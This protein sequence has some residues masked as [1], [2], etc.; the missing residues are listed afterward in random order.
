MALMLTTWM[1]GPEPKVTESA[2][3]VG[4]VDE[5]DSAPD[6]FINHIDDNV[7]SYESNHYFDN[8]KSVINSNNGNEAAFNVSFQEVENALRMAKLDN[9]GEL[10]LDE[11]ALA[12]LNL[13]VSRLP[14][15]LTPQNIQKIQSLIMKA[16]PG[17]A[18]EQVAEVL[19]NYYHFKQA[20]KEWLSSGVAV[21]SLQAAMD[22]LEKVSAMRQE[23]LGQDMADKLFLRQQQKASL[24]FQSMAIQQNK[25]LSA[26]Q[27]E[28][29]LAALSLN[30][31]NSRSN[32]A[33]LDRDDAGYINSIE[34][35]QEVQRLNSDIESMRI[36][37]ATHSDI[38]SKR[39]EVLGEQ[40]ASQ[41]QAMETQKSQWENRYQTYK[42]DKQHILESAITDVDKQQ[43]I[44]ALL[45]EHYSNDELAGARAY[46]SQQAH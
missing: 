45:S 15:N 5:F 35:N 34:N 28:T 3:N 33:N 32:L 39:V 11:Q 23:Y 38:H 2:F 13:V 7:I 30:N 43:Q 10:I 17:E 24:S 9:V 12:S 6:D 19:G 31:E 46:D 4:S 42:E 16:Q 27:K 8:T 41:M 14:K 36:S 1:F 29:E 37:G 21:N 18:G 40:A 25:E 22:Q 44:E 26:E 20:E